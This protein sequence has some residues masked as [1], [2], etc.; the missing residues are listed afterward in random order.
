MS[1]RMR[2]SFRRAVV[3]A[4]A[5]GLCTAFGCAKGTAEIGVA[6]D[7]SGT[8][9]VK[10]ITSKDS[11]QRWQALTAMMQTLGLPLGPL[12][13]L[14]PEGGGGDGRMIV[15]RAELEQ[16]GRQLGPDVR[17]VE[18]RRLAAGAEEGVEA[19]YVFPDVRKVRW[20]CPDAQGRPDGTGI[21]FDF[22][23]GPTALLK[24]SPFGLEGRADGAAIAV[25]AESP[26]LDPLLKAA[27]AGLHLKLTL[28]V[29]GKVLRTS[30][31]TVEPPGR[32]VLAEIQAARMRPADLWTLL[33]VR[34]LT[35]AARLQRAGLAGVRIEDLSRPLPV[36]FR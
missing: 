24:A 30:A 26:L 14:A 1:D 12:A 29:D 31:A 32:I 2:M 6:A 34:D 18:A 33:Q 20:N 13:S 9:N 28:R 19:R 23:P 17:M 8:L 35:G 11:L 21:R 10:V 5:C 7:G 27:F 3:A 4:A 22:Q 16:L 36:L 15:S 25:R